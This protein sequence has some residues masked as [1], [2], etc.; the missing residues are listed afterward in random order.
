MDTVDRATRSRQNRTTERR[1]RAY[2]ASAGVSGWQL[3]PRIIGTPDF[4]FPGPRL[5]LFVD[6]CFWHGCPECARGHLPRSNTAYWHPKIARNQARDRAVTA[7]LRRRGW[8]V[9]RI[10]EHDL[11]DDPLSV[12]DAV[13]TA[14]RSR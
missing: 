13:R 6:G 14:L 8:S 2:P 1:L 9:L 7:Q 10:W 11:A 5:A 12:I 4:A 3:H